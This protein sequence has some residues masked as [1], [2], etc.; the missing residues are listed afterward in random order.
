MDKPQIISI[1]YSMV[2]TNEIIK[3]ILNADEKAWISVEDKTLKEK[4]TKRKEIRYVSYQDW[5][6]V[7]GDKKGNRILITILCDAVTHP[8]K[9]Q[10]YWQGV[11]N[12]IEA[13]IK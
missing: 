13:H 7:P 3:D 11:A 10:K 1:T 4:L 8:D 9:N 12:E 2:L 6:R 5:E